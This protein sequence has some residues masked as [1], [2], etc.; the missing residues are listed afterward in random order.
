MTL[1]CTSSTVESRIGVRF[2]CK[3]KR[4]P[5]WNFAD[6]WHSR[7]RG[8]WEVSRAQDILRHQYMYTYMYI[9]RG[10]VKQFLLGVSRHLYR[11]A[12]ANA[13]RFVLENCART[14][15]YRATRALMAARR[16]AVKAVGLTKRFDIC[17]CSAPCD[18]ETRAMHSRVFINFSPECSFHFCTLL[19]C[20]SFFAVFVLLFVELFFYILVIKYIINLLL[21]NFFAQVIDQWI[22]WPALCNKI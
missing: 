1:F 3:V 16:A 8:S 12:K 4:E 10:R 7:S 20:V 9:Y 17:R 21:I 15:A 11:C 19:V 6:G 22:K 18:R 5:Y 14:I 13:P 2:D